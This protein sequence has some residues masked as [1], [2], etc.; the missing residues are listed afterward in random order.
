[1]TYLNKG[2]FYGVTLNELSASKRLRHPISKVRVRLFFFLIKHAKHSSTTQQR[3]QLQ[4]ERRTGE[5]MCRLSARVKG[6]SLSE[7]G[8]GGVQ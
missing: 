1:M 6:L 2:Q 8:H 5:R 3:T 4:R 7:R